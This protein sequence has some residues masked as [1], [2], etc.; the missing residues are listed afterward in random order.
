MSDID[1]IKSKIDVVEFVGKYVP[2][3]KAGVNY[4]GM[5][6]F[7]QEKTPSFIVSPEKQIWHCFGC[8][9]G[10]DVFKFLM[11]REGIEFP[12]A[13]KIL[14]EQVGVKLSKVPS[15]SSDSKKVLYTINELAAK[16]FEKVMSDSSEGR[17][18]KDYFVGRGLTPQTI[19]EFRLGYAPSNG[20]ALI[21]FLKRKNISEKDIERA[22]L[23]VYKGKFLRDKFVSRAMFPLTDSLGRVVAFTGRVLD[24]K[25][26]PKYLNSPETPIFRKSEL[27]Y[28]LDLAKSHIQQGG[29]VV[30]VEGQM[31]VISSHQADVKNTVGVSG[32]AFTREQMKIISRYASEILMA[33]DADEAG[34]E[35][36]KRAIGLASEFDLNIKVILLGEH[37]DPDSLIKDDANK[38][39]AAVEKAV[40][41]VDFHFDKAIKKYDLKNLDQR[42]GLTRELLAIINKLTD[43][44]EKDHYIKKLGNLVNVNPKILYD[45]LRRVKPVRQ[46]RYSGRTRQEE[47]KDVSPTWLEERAIALAVSYPSLLGSFMEKTRD[48]KW[49]SGLAKTIYSEL[50]NCYTA[51]DFRIDNLLMKLPPT[52]KTSLLELMLVIEQSYSGA[53]TANIEEEL[54]FYLNILQSRSYAAKRYELVQLIAAAES[55]H[56]KVKLKTLL[57]E[58]NK[59]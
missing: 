45:A 37:K 38:W 40:A 54:S 36:T 52:I 15:G 12:E 28:G 1:L 30:L 20:R 18:A 33:L 42:K 29:K 39:K 47:I 9:R 58:L 7:H 31:D 11:E 4:K 23:G 46:Q 10:G 3:K 43:P 35:A 48:M 57:E 16:Y 26:V 13:L 55:A 17:K 19:Q 44:V 50:T 27:L 6:P 49:A 21:D 41:V 59:L 25:A 2:L 53:D 34:S 32:T 8:G 56:D 22:G 5:C 51:K 24:S 14:A